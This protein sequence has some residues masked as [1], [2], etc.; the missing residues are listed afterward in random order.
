MSRETKGRGAAGHSPKMRRS[1][2]QRGGRRQKSAAGGRARGANPA[3]PHS[4]PG[5]PSLLLCPPPPSSAWEDVPPRTARSQGGGDTRA[6]EAPRSP[7]NTGP[8]HQPTFAT[9]PRLPSP[10]TRRRLCRAPGAL[11]PS[12]ASHRAGS[13]RGQGTASSWTGGRSSQ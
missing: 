12:P 10:I 13:R 3:P 6:S 7:L 8:S 4:I 2:G 5:V 1:R 9:G 11:S